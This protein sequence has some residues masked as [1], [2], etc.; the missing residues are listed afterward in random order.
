[1][2]RYPSSDRKR[3]RD[4]RETP[5][6]AAAP[7]AVEV[8]LQTAFASL[9][10]GNLDQAET[11]CR[12]ILRRAPD[13]EDAAY[14]LGRVLER[15]GRLVEAAEFLRRAIAADPTHGPYHT[16]LGEV[17]NAAGD[18]DGAIE[19]L[20]EAVR[21]APDD[22][23]PRNSLGLALMN[24]GRFV[25]AERCFREVLDTD[26][27]WPGA[28]LSL[29]RVRRFKPEDQSLV[30]KMRAVL[31]HTELPDQI[32]SDVHFALGKVHDDL[33]EPDTAFEHY[34]RGN[35]LIRRHV[36]FDAARHAASVDALTES[37]TTALF[38]RLRE[39]GE[40]SERP[41]FIVGM[42]RSGTT[43]VEQI[44]ASHHQVHG[45][46]EL[47]YLD[48]LSQRLAPC[49]GTTEPYP[50]CASRLDA[51]CASALGREYLQ[52]VG[53]G[54]G[55]ALRCTDK[56][57]GNFMHLGLVALVLPRARVVH[58]RRDPM[59]TGLSIYTQQFASGHEW[60][61][62]LEDIAAFYQQ[63]RR[64]MRHWEQV[65]PLEVMEVQ[66]EALVERQ[67]QVSRELVDF[68][69]LPWDAACLEY[70]RQRRSVGT[71]ANWQV[72]QP[73]YRRSVGRWHRYERDLR[74]LRDALERAREIVM[75]G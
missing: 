5:S 59:D 36:R 29:S 12:E 1:M 74:P 68:C 54:A 38:A 40:P 13:H 42:P 18:S 61:Y 17:L 63:Y 35:E 7:R 3:R 49:L 70:Y 60:A 71:A 41:V 23:Q 27:T 45:G 46:G 50:R 24:A 53:A 32:L 25:K 8:A 16:S 30:R 21:L 66:Y 62:D 56:M 43:L 69:G 65:L 10:D 55:D 19:I 6:A 48:A 28:C 52:R 31:G 75:P 51:A 72:R 34:R 15:A 67:E 58:C 57:P 9:V 11:E 33:E 37:F 22:P 26:P 20:R 73:I 4:V 47:P 2:S 14:L 44:L 39:I 64:I